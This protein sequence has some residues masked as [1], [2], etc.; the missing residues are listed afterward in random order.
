MQIKSLTTTSKQ[1]TIFDLALKL[2][3][4][5]GTVFSNELKTI[6]NLFSFSSSGMKKLIYPSYGMKHV[7]LI[8]NAKDEEKM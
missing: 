8:I 1:G 6:R 7:V 5:K 2:T 3:I 4:L